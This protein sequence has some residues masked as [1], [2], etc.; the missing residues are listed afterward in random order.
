LLSKIKSNKGWLCVMLVGL[1]AGI[2]AG[3]VDSGSGWMVN[4]K[5]GVC[6]NAFWLNREQCCWDSDQVSFD[7]YK[8]I[9][10]EKV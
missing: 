8:N 6:K 9:Q 5:S 2:V 7:N 1:S 3:L 4:L 10:C